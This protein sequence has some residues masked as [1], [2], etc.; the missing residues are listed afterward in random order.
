MAVAT[1][2]EAV[3]VLRPLIAEPGYLKA[4]ADPDAIV[5]TD[6]R[7]N[8][9]GVL[10]IARAFDGE[11]AGRRGPDPTGAPPP[12]LAPSMRR[13]TPAVPVTRPAGRRAQGPVGAGRPRPPG[14]GALAR[15]GRAWDGGP[16]DPLAPRLSLRVHFGDG[17]TLGPGKALLLERIRDE[18]SISAAGRAMG[19]SYRRAWSLVE[20]MNAA[21]A[22]PL[23]DSARGGAGGGG[24]RLTE[25]GSEALRRFRALEAAVLDGGGADLAGLRAMLREGS[26]GRTGDRPGR[27]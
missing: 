25:A 19:M 6:A 4:F 5:V 1:S 14:S 11:T 21:F 13:S 16:M 3:R 18:G 26:A 17:L 10:A 23:V 27:T 24:A 22:D 20:E 12:R 8:V 9:E 2:A 15:R 7:A